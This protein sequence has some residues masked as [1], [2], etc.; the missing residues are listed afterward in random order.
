MGVYLDRMRTRGGLHKRYIS[1][2]WTFDLF[3]LGLLLFY[4]H[5]LSSNSMKAF[6]S[7]DLHLLMYYLLYMYGRGKT[8]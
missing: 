5:R 3:T 6:P 1:G 8:L 4:C 2:S 7:V